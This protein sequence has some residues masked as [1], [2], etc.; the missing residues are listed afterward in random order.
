MISLILGLLIFS[1]GLQ[2]ST[3]DLVLNVENISSEKGSILI[4]VFDKEE[5][6]LKKPFKSYIKAVDSEDIVTL[7][8]DD[9]P[10]GN[11]AISIFLDENDNKELDTN[12]FGIPKEAFGFSNNKMG[13]MGPP[14]FE[15]SKINYKGKGEVITI[16]LRTIL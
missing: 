1:Q 9:L 14:S 15:D 7:K 16:R 2:N 12:A 13:I 11:Y 5:D 4:A 6:F 3:A 10:L 8:L